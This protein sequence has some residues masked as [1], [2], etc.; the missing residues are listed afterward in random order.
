[1]ASFFGIDA[2]T[3]MLKTAD[4]NVRA[5][6]LMGRVQVATALAQDFDGGILF[7][8][9][10]PFDRLIFSYA[11]SIMDDWRPACAHAF[12]QLKPG[13]TIHVVDF[14]DQEGLPNWFKKF[15][16][17]WLAQFHVRFRPEV[18]AYFEALEREGRGTMTYRS[19]MRGYA[20]R[21]DFTTKA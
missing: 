5:S 10:K 14:G 11:L 3:E 12:S 4:A 6:G 21:L 2:S 17:G 1:G 13:G 19:L 9:Q 20:Y 15:L 8:L 16:G 7:G 18:R